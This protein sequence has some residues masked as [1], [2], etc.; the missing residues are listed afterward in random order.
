MNLGRN[1]INGI[2]IIQNN[3][4]PLFYVN[5]MTPYIHTKIFFGKSHRKMLNSSCVAHNFTAFH[6]KDGKIYGIGGQDNWKHHPSWYDAYTFPEFQEI[7]SDV[8]GEKYK[9]GEKE[10]IEALKKINMLRVP[11]KHTRGLYL[12][13]TED[14]KH[15]KQDVL[16]PIIKTTHP[17]F[18]SALS[19]K[20]SEF[21]GQCSCVWNQEKELYYLFVRENIAP[22]LRHVQYSTSK[23]LINWNEFKRVEL[24]DYN[25]EMNYYYMLV[26]KDDKYYGLIPCYYEGNSYIKVYESENCEEWTFLR[27][28][29]T[30]KSIFIDD[31]EKCPTHPCGG[32]LREGKRRF[33]YLYHNY[34]S[35]KGKAY[36]KKYEF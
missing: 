13:S 20:S 17:G 8:H 5:Y 22:G 7:F 29:V 16:N 12:F 28:F 31:V 27:D 11:Y 23:D 36:V 2:H 3:S 10:G 25:H 30:E 32:I 6:G 26:S 18:N 24:N 15:W 14:G 33:I 4:E 21:D 9:K 35:Y 1:Q 34:Y 19:W